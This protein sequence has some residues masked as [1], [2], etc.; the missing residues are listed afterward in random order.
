LIVLD[1]DALEKLTKFLD[2]E[3]KLLTPKVFPLIITP[4][5]K[6]IPLD[7]DLQSQSS[8]YDTCSHKLVNQ[9]SEATTLT[10]KHLPALINKM[11][12]VCSVSFLQYSPPALSVFLF[13]FTGGGDGLGY[14]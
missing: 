4:N 3:N 2:K 1:G 13:L 9:R 7:L 5:C 6:Y 14:N 11:I 12:D 8:A 10:D